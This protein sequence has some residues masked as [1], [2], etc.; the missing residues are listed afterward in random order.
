MDMRSR[1]PLG[2]TQLEILRLVNAGLSNREIADRLAI[3]VGTTK[4]HLCQIFRKFDVKNRTAA[5]AR[6]RELDLLDRAR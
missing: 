6:G 2:H 5:A 4:W 3:T 1:P